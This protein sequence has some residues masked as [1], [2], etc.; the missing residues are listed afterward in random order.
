MIRTARL[1]LCGRQ[2]DMLWRFLI[3]SQRVLL[4]P[5]DEVKGHSLLL[6][7]KCLLLSMGLKETENKP[8][9]NF[10]RLLKA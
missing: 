4:T 3:C 9:R 2:E 10:E 8:E 1:Y 6:V 7:N 5:V